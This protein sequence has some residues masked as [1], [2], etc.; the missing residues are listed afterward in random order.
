MQGEVR[1]DQVEDRRRKRQRAE[2]AL[3]KRRAG[4]LEAVADRA[5]Q[6]PLQSARGCNEAR[7]VRE[8]AARR[9]DA[10]Y[11]RLRETFGQ[12]GEIVAAP[13]TRVEHRRRCDL[14]VIEPLTHALRDF[15]RQE[16][17]LAERGGT[18]VENAC[19]ATDIGIRPGRIGIG[20][21]H[22]IS[23]FANVRGEAR[24]Y[25]RSPLF[26]SSDETCRL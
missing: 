12:R 8:H 15:A 10:E 6:E 24:Q 22:R 3:R 18:P 21:R 1:P 5:R 2:V 17:D 20:R 26:T 23:G 14:Y 13:A 16:G 4:A 19:D 7:Y 11:G 9:I 25:T